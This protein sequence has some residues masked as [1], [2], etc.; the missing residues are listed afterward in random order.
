MAWEQPQPFRPREAHQGQQDRKHPELLRLV[1]PFLVFV[2]LMAKSIETEFGLIDTKHMSL[3]GKLTKSKLIA[4]GQTAFTDRKERD[5]PA[6]SNK[7]TA[8]DVDAVVPEDC[9]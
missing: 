5:T 4:T 8:R 7:T 6:G 9:Y 3:C 2:L 1:D